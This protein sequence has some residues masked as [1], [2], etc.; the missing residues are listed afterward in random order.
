MSN[1]VGV[2]EKLAELPIIGD[3]KVLEYLVF[4][5]EA[6]APDA[7]FIRQVAADKGFSHVSVCGI[8]LNDPKAE[9]PSFSISKS[10]DVRKAALETGYRL[11]QIAADVSP[12]GGAPRLGGPF[13]MMHLEKNPVEPEEYYRLVDFLTKM[14][15]RAYD[16]GVELDP[17]VLNRFELPGPNNGR[18]VVQLVKDVREK[19]KKMNPLLIK[20]QYDLFH[21][22][23]E[24][25]KPEE[26]IEYLGK[27][28]CLGTVHLGDS[29]RLALNTGALKGKFGRVLKAIYDAT[30]DQPDDVPVVPEIFCPEF[31]KN[32]AIWPW[33]TEA[34]VDDSYTQA[35]D[36]FGVLNT[37]IKNYE[38]SGRYL[39]GR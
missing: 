39:L 14:V 12:E 3:K 26:A 6:Q 25:E 4:D 22:S 29:N 35:K 19:A 7:G 5:T 1:A 27:N 38:R 11:I 20:S 33:P 17:E 21:S 2:I 28:D 18:Q 23:L 8:N 16:V 10:E 37:H 30:K 15:E 36:S 24:F 34:P 32:V 31:G 9:G 13:Y